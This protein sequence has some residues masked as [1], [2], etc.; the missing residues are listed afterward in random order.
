MILL[1]DSKGIANSG[2]QKLG[3]T[4]NTD[5]SSFQQLLSARILISGSYY[6]A[7]SLPGGYLAVDAKL[8]E[9]LRYTSRC[10]MFSTSPMHFVM[11]MIKQSLVSLLK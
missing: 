6:S 5:F 11:A 9:E 3:V 2:P 4:D 7:S 1:K 10:Y 8:I